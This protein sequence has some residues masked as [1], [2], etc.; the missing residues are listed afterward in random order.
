RSNLKLDG[1]SATSDLLNGT[2]WDSVYVAYRNSLLRILPN[3]VI[4]LIDS[5][6]DWRTWSFRNIPSPPPWL[7]SGITQYM[8]EQFF[9]V[10]DKA[11]ATNN[12]TLAAFTIKSLATSIAGFSLAV[13][14]FVSFNGITAIRTYLETGSLLAAFCATSPS[15]LG[16][17]YNQTFA[18]RV[19]R[20]VSRR[21]S[22]TLSIAWGSRTRGV[23]SSRTSPG[24][25][26]PS[27]RGHQ[28]SPSPSLRNSQ[29]WTWTKTGKANF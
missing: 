4:G 19:P 18:S 10:R 15:Q 3:T 29:R 25:E 23:P 13:L 22:R 6:N 17:L 7:S 20:T 12:A 11:L 24:S 9:F 28:C 1:S 5:S 8:Q 14:D 2:H 26:A 21:S 27:Q 16:V